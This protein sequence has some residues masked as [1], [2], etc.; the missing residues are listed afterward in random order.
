VIRRLL[1]VLLMLLA[2]PAA[3]QPTLAGR[4][5]EGSWALRVEGA[6]IMRF[7]LERQGEGWGGAWTKPT[8]FRS[9]GVR[10]GNIVM[11]ATT[12][13]ADRGQAIGEW[14]EIIFDDPRPNEEPDQFRF[15]LLAPDRAELLYVGTGL[16]PFILERVAAGAPLGPFTEGAVYGGPLTTPGPVTQRPVVAPPPAQA[17][18]QTPTPTVPPVQTPPP[19]P[20][21]A[22]PPILPRPEQVRPVPQTPPP[23]EE[24]PPVQ[25]PPVMIGR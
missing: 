20:P 10:F 9:D 17:P 25:G 21:P 11:P 8:S 1:I 18:V 7:D 13:R 24:P 2:V 5:L 22:L 15:R 23:A 19:T 16:P 14:A 3:A 4:L 12:R 6:I